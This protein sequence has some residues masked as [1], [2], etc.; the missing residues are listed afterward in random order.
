ME[1]QEL[2]ISHASQIISK[3]T[4]SS[5]D[6]AD[7]LLK[8]ISRFE[9]YLNAWVTIDEK[10]VIKDAKNLDIEL[11]NHGPRS[12]IHGIPIGLKDI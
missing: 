5:L 2:S 6:L 4:L 11:A 3:G 12:P 8:E 7:A 9:K 10:Q 1:L